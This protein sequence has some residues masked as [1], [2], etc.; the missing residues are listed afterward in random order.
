MNYIKKLF[1]CILW[2]DYII[3][4]DTEKAKQRMRNRGAMIPLSR[5]GSTTYQCT[6]CKKE[7]IESWSEM[8]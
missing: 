2:H 7:K 4:F 6:K 5:C 1:E 3:K 8:W